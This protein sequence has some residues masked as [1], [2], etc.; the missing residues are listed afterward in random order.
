MQPL[1][2]RFLPED[3]AAINGSPESTD[4]PLSDPHAGIRPGFAPATGRMAPAPPE[5][6]HQ[7][8]VTALATGDDRPPAEPTHE[9][10]AFRAG[11]AGSRGGNDHGCGQEQR[12]P[13]TRTR[14]RSGAGA[15]APGAPP[16]PPTAAPGAAGSAPSPRR[17]PGA[18][19]A[20]AA[21]TARTGEHVD[22]ERPPH[23]TTAIIVARIVHVP[24]ASLFTQG[25][26]IRI[27]SS[28]SR[29]GGRRNSRLC[30]VGPDRC[31]WGG[32]HADVIR[33]RRR[34]RACP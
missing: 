18:R 31:R 20:A 2:R 19:P 23:A 17:P 22:L 14:R 33:R 25:Q 9:R 24:H 27:A 1:Q 29:G 32:A 26:I 6:R 15:P 21:P 13:L 3:E 30:L 16:E 28:M 7:W 5:D 8:P 10:C 11:R 12:R 34:R 4:R